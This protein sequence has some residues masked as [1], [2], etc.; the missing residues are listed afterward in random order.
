M[1]DER[2]VV[3]WIRHG[4]RRRVDAAESGTGH[5]TDITGA[6]ELLRNDL[7]RWSRW[8]LGLGAF[9]LA[10][11]ASAAA[12]SV[13]MMLLID[14]PSGTAGMLV[15][16][17][18]AAVAV[19]ALVTVT[20]VLWGL[21][22][23]GRRPARALRWWLIQRSGAMPERAFSGWVAPRAAFFNPAVF[24]RVLASTLAGLVGVF[25]FSLFAY[26]LAERL[27]RPLSVERRSRS[28]SYC[29]TPDR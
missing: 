3:F 18:V 19:A 5:T 10:V 27:H 21:H 15:A 7:M 12:G 4:S 25:G 2:F 29:A 26:A 8:W 14:A 22:R 9:S 24:V 20:F 1:T 6:S 23:S 17:V 28:R 13:S 16:V 11:V